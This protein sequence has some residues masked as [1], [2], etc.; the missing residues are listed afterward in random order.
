MMFTASYL[1]SSDSESGLEDGIGEE[2]SLEFCSLF[3]NV[4]LPKKGER[5]AYS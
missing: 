5:K 2:L 1:E 3:K 4:F